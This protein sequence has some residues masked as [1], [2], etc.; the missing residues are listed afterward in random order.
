MFTGFTDETVQ[1]FMDLRFHNYTEYFHE[2]HDR[3]VETVQQPFYS[4]IE[5]L[6][7][8]MLEIDP[9][10]EIRPHRC[11]S[12]IHR[13]TRFSRDK[14]PYRDHLWFLF[15]REGE[16]RE[17][18]LFYYGEFGP[19]RLGWGMGFWGENR[20]AM[21]IFRKRMAANPDGVL[22]LIRDMNLPDH[23]LGLGGTSFK[24]FPVPPQIPPLLT[25][26]YTAREIYVAK[27]DPEYGIAFSDRLAREMKKDFLA[28][29]P[30]YRTL[31]GICDEL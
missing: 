5:D 8:T 20:E 9:M 6:S 19:E 31:R 21:D 22:A 12:R 18:S 1:F 11:I 15:R 4:L 17:K 29:A 13:D 2:N 14:S 26:W 10:T 24:R 30:L 23:Q 3:Y 28:M 16:P 7:P 25:R 27:V